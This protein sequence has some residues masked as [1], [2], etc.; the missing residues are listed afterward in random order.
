M[1][2]IDTMFLVKIIKQTQ[3]PNVAL[4]SA[5]ISA[6]SLISANRPDRL[7]TLLAEHFLLLRLQEVVSKCYPAPNPNQKKLFGECRNCE[8]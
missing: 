2:E 6:E 1:R 8:L 3:R 4:G 7:W 5:R